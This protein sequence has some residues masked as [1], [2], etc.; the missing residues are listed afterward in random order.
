[1][2]RLIKFLGVILAFSTIGTVRA[3]E[4]HDFH[5]A[6]TD[7]YSHYR[8]ASF[9]IH[10]GNPGVAA[11]ELQS[12]SD[13]WKDLAAKFSAN[14]PSI[15]STDGKW[16]A[17]LAE[18]DK[19][20]EQGM[21][22][23]NDGDLKAAKSELGPIRSLLADLRKRNGVISFSDLVDNAN[24]AYDALYHFRHEPPD[25]SKPESVDGARRALSIVQYWYQRCLDE[26]PEQYAKQPL[27]QRLVE[28][29]VQS[30]NRAWD[31][32]NKKQQKRFIN[33]LREVRASDRM[34]FLR[35]G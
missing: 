5:A 12:L 20:I 11:L 10:T 29:S 6:V 15:Y 34:L 28:D 19:R 2:G 21:G 25:F 17:T 23:A 4:V 1:M 3:A 32:L 8:E 22:A 16:G 9:Y 30:L 13:K 14:P 18:I 7:A 31:A 26:A 24:K 33:I 27:F 35:Y